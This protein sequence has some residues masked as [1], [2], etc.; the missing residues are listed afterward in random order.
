MYSCIALTFEAIL[1]PAAYESVY[2]TVLNDGETTMNDWNWD[3]DTRVKDQGLLR[4]MQTPCH[5]I[6]LTTV[7]FALEP[8]KPLTI[9]LQ[10]RNQDIYQAY[11]LVDETIDFIKSRRADINDTFDH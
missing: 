1:N 5:A 2:V 9:K 8:I 6:S 11:K 3:R 7:M 4:T 10:K